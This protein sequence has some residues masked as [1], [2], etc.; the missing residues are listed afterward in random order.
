MREPLTVS[1]L[2]NVRDLGGL[3]RADG[4]TTPWGAFVRAERLDRIDEAGWRALRDYG[5]ATV[6]DLR[7]PGESSGDVP[8]WITRVQVDL[9]GDEAEFWRPFEADGRWGTPLYYGA[10]LRELPHRLGAV[11]EVLAQAPDGAI[12]FHCSAGWDRTG[13]LAAFLLRALD[14]APEAAI[15]DYLASFANVDAMEALHERSFEAV[16]RRAILE[17]FGHTPESA[18]LEMYAQLNI[19]F[20]LHAADL[21]LATRAATLT[22]RGH[23]SPATTAT[24]QMDP[25]SS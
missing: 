23:A 22:W 19:T 24:R 2:A 16:E 7:R 3:E 5:V 15:A 8:R 25:F 4:T 18:F 11:L 17:R 12:L 13:L 6:V 20:L 1:G 14:V 10:H 9:D 21:D